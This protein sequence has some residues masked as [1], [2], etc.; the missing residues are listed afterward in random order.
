[1]VLM[2]HDGPF[3][4]PDTLSPLFKS[5]FLD[6]GILQPYASDHTKRRFLTNHILKLNT[7]SNVSL[8]FIEFPS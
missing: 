8:A 2:K 4:M 1:M 7:S 5:I 6:S 3:Q